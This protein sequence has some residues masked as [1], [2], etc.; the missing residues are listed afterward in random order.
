MATTLATMLAGTSD[1]TWKMP[2]VSSR[3]TCETTVEITETPAYL[4]S[5]TL[6]GCAIICRTLACSAWSEA[7]MWESGGWPP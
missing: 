2:N 6:D 5:F 1:M 3:V 4:M 7:Q